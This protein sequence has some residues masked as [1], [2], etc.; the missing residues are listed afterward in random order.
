[1][2][3]LRQFLPAL[4]MPLTLSVALLIAAALRKRWGYLWSGL[5]LLWI[6]SMPIA[7]TGL[8]RVMDGGAE[9]PL[10]SQ[11]PAADAIVVLSGV[12]LIAPG[13]A[14]VSEWTDANRF[15]GGLELFRAR[16]APR[17]VFTGARPDGP[18]DAPLEGQTLR[19]YAQSMG[20]PA[21]SIVTTGLVVNT[22]DEARAV[23]ALLPARS[24]IL[25]VTSAY[26]MP[27]A[28]RLFE[29]AGLVVAPFPVDFKYA[30]GHALTPTD[31]LPSASALAATH[32]FVREALGRLY[33]H[34]F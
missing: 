14:G 31:F 8:A 26:H 30:P 25:L 19:E 12:R 24:R 17:L 7:A 11:A 13:P 6:S 29:R 33:Y 22:D 16:K 32:T 18:D 9:R 15:F 2:F 21:Q 10:A 4:V 1:M 20:V 3:F 23:S 34:L 5:A 28:Q 27:R